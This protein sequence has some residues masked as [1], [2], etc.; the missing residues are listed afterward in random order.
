VI[1]V[2]LLTKHEDGS[3]DAMELSDV[4]AL[5]ELR[6]LDRGALGRGRRHTARGG[7]G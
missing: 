5:G 4:G 3:I 7:D 6:E 2:L 1:D